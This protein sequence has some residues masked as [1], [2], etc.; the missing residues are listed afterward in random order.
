MDTFSEPPTDS[1]TTGTPNPASEPESSTGARPGR[2]GYSRTPTTVGKA[3]A[4]LGRA[5][6]AR[7]AKP[8]GNEPWRK[9]SLRLLL[10]NDAP[11]A[12]TDGSRPYGWFPPP[13]LT[14]IQAAGL[15]ALIERGEAAL[16]PAGPELAG[17]LL[18]DIAA[19]CVHGERIA[20]D[21][22]MKIYV[23]QLSPLPRDLL[24]DAC[25][26]WIRTEKFW[27]TVAE[28]R[29]RVMPVANRRRAYYRRALILR[30]VADNPAPDGLVTHAWLREREA[31]GLAALDPAPAPALLTAA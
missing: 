13:S 20:V 14:E 21:R 26:D 25:L 3:V 31:A 12:E 6:K 28:L 18:L 11:K 29:E 22:A 19:V 7:P 9:A 2:T 16:Q 8:T 10:S 30:S 17:T 15:P 1:E 23:A 5:I 24:H 4:D 27:P